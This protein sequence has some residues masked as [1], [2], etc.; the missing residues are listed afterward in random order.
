MLALWLLVVVVGA[1]ALVE[2]PIDLPDN[3]QMTDPQT[4]SQGNY[5]LIDHEDGTRSSYSHLSQG[6]V[7]VQPGE[8]VTTGQLIGLSGYSGNAHAPHLHFTVFAAPTS[9]GARYSLP[10]A[11]RNVGGRLDPRGGLMKGVVYEALP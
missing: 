3:A 10:V 7:F 4:D 6:N 9:T 8:T 11:F 2:L 5:I 1:T